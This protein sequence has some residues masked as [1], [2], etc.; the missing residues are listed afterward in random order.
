M[1]IIGVHSRVTPFLIAAVLLLQFSPALATGQ[2]DAQQATIQ[3]SRFPG[4]AVPSTETTRDNRPG[5]VEVTFTK[6]ITGN[7]LVPDNFGITEGRG[8]MAG[9]TG[10]D[11][12]GTFV[13]EVIQGQRSA[14]PALKT[15]ISKLESIYEVH[16]L[17]GNHVF[18]AL[19]RGGTNRATGAALL[20]GVV[21][22]GW[23]TGAA[24]H[25]EFETYAPPPTGPGCPD[26]RA[27]ADR[28]CLVGT[29]HI[30]RAPKEQH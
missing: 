30:E 18:T 7:V 23:R 10:G 25:V 6:W 3:G 22:A 9:F 21:L 20:S 16:D 12:P 26:T 1:R 19:I 8:L 14:N 15:G 28:T 11:I 24:V 27:P 17:N 2:Q 4:M 13:G 29:I 5:P